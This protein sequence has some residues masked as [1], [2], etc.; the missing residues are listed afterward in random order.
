MFSFSFSRPKGAAAERSI[1]RPLFSI[2]LFACAVVLASTGCGGGSTDPNPTDNTDNG[3]TPG[4]VGTPPRLKV[5]GTRAGTAIS[6]IGSPNVTPTGADDFS[7]LPVDTGD[8]IALNYPSTYTI[9]AP[10]IWADR[11]F[12]EWRL[13]GT[14]F[15][16]VANLQVSQIPSSANGTLTAVY[17]PNTPAGAF[18]PNY[19]GNL[20]VLNH[21]QTLPIKIWV[22]PLLA[23]NA[24]EEQLLFNG[25]DKWKRASGGVITYTKVKTSGEADIRLRSVD[26]LLNVGPGVLGVNLSIPEL[27]SIN[28]DLDFSTLWLIR[29][30][31]AVQNG[32][33]R[34][35]YEAIV[36]HEFGHALGLQGHSDV[37]TDLMFPFIG[38]LELTD[39]DINTVATGY[40]RYFDGGNTVPK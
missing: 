27:D 29:A 9:I 15:E 28:N 2:G 11:K 12:K 30:Q 14:V 3:G 5:A 37:E 6:F 16:T 40:K 34:R 8:G 18:T 20:R 1:G 23:R 17:E 21:F 10:Q 31:S 7:V 25:I 19:A 36:A 26:N 39:R 24:T 33:E 35:Q 32:A 13:N 4:V 22:D 38:P